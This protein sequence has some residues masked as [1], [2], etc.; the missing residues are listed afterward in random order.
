ME[1]CEL[2]DCKIDYLATH[3][4]LRVGDEQHTM[5]RLKAFSERYGGRK[6]WLTEFAVRNTHNEDDVI[7]VIENLLP[8]YVNFFQHFY[9]NETNL[10]FTHLSSVKYYN[11]A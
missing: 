6:I 4:Y 11:I 8:M 7:G 1:A 9:N 3:Q 5:D 2:L 10:I